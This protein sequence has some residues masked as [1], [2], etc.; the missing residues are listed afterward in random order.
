MTNALIFLLVF[1]DLSLMSFPS[2]AN[3]LIV[4]GLFLAAVNLFLFI[5][6]GISLHQTLLLG[7]SAELLLVSGDLILMGFPG[8]ADSLVV[9]G[10]LLRAVNLVFIIVIKLSKSTI[11]LLMGSNLILMSL[12]GLADSLVIWIFLLVAV[13]FLLVVIEDLSESVRIFFQLIDTDGLD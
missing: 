3:S 4:L 11:L 1:S 5:V 12:P 2:S 10:L 6:K 9:V 13:N 8:L 7:D